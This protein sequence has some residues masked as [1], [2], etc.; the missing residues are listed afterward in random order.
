MWTVI[1]ESMAPSRLSSSS[2][3]R[4]ACAL[5]STMASLQNSMPVQAITER[6]Q[7]SGRADRSSASAPA[8]SESTW[9]GATSRTRIFCIGVVR[10]RCEPCASARSA[11]AS[12]ASAP[13]DPPGLGREAD[14]L[15][16]SFCSLHADV[17]AGA[18]GRR[19]RR[20][21]DERAVQVLVLE[22]LAELLGAPV[23]D[24]ELDPGPGAQPAVAVV[25]ED[26]AHAGPDLGD[27]VARHP[28]AEPLGEHRVG[29]QPAADPDVEA[30]AVLGVLDA[31][32][33]DVVDLVHDVLQRVAGDRG[34][35]LAR[36]VRVLRVADEAV[37]DLVDGR[38]RVDD[39]VGGDPGHRA[40]RGS[41]RGQSPQAS[42]VSRPTAS[43]RRQISGH[44]LDADPVQLDVLPVG[45]VGGAAGEVDRDLADHAQLL[46]GQ[47]TAVDAD[48]Q[49]EVLVVELVRLERRGL[50][51]V[52]AGLALG[53][54]AVPAEPAAQV[55]RVDRG[56]AA[57]A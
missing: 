54:E 33:G 13:L 50:A 28:G 11:S 46:A 18:L 34:L 4:A 21:V 49:H 52:D 24:E 39:L 14:E 7:A 12:E 31:D 1:G 2:T 47:G 57:V 10:S 19:G 42:V 20:A 30:G 55:A 16:P 43:R 37:A 3:T 38:R 5:V 6:R 35:E 9:S 15:A 41:T 45:D 23:G 29:R 56:E 26:A 51:A 25:A 53:V 40:S 44:V 17:V 48:A 27:L 8:T 36:Q 32:E 22:H